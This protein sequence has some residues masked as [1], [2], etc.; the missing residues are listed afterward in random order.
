MATIPTVDLSDFKFTAGIDYITLKG[1][2][3]VA[4]PPLSGKAIWPRKFPG[5]LTVHDATAKDVRILAELFPNGIID[6]LEVRVDIRSAKQLTEELQR[7]ALAAFKAEF[8]AKG[9]LPDFIAGTNSGFRGAYDHRI[10]K[11]VP[12]NH[13]V[14]KADQQLLMGHRNDGAQV[15]SYYKRLDQHQYLAVKQ[16]CIR[17]EV[18]LNR[19]ALDHHHLLTVRDLCG[20]KFRRGLMRYFSHVSGSRARKA[21]KS[22]RTPLLELLHATMEK[23]DNPY[24]D[25]VGIGAFLEGGK[26]HRANIIF[27]RDTALNDRIGQALGRLEKSFSAEKFVRLLIFPSTRRP[28]SMRLP[29]AWIKSAMTY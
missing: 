22:R 24:W 4:L 21:R 19:M 14:P 15:K 7:K 10:Q 2:P 6:E 29:A 16:H 11:T 23:I 28:V 13:R 26:R 3:K 18:R 1:L 12:Y 20:F 8:V 9:L 27:R 5:R 17:V 25:R